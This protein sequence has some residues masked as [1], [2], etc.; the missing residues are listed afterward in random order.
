L[1]F[2]GLAGRQ[3]RLIDMMGSEVYIRDGNGLIEPGLYIDLGA[4]GCNVF[5]LDSIGS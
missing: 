4:W 1:P 5:R 2:S 3:Y